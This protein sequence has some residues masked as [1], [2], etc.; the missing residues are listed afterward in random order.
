MVNSEETKRQN[1]ERKFW[2]RLAP[3]YDKIINRDSDTYEAILEWL[4]PELN[5]EMN[6]LELASGT[7][8]VSL[9]AA[10][11]V[12]K[13]TG[14]DITEAMVA[15]AES[16]AEA[17][18]ITNCEFL[19][20]DAYHLDFDDNT[21]DM[22]IITNALHVMANPELVIREARRVLKDRG[23]LYVPTYLHGSSFRSMTVSIISSLFG[24]KV[25]HRWNREKFIKSVTDEM[26]RLIHEETLEGL[27]P[28][29]ILAVQKVSE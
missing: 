27:F 26:F 23:L 7:G 3:R 16:K 1:K 14:C 6:V 19:V 2:Q 28:L 4:I 15:I 18:G 11:H 9:K 24:F 17:S 29:S 20:Q 22:V 8:A 5:P 10:P 21:F 25:F 12:K 13:L